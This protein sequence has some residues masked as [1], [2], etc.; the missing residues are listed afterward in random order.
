MQLPY[1]IILN[2]AILFQQVACETLEYLL[3]SKFALT[4]MEAIKLKVI[5]IASNIFEA[6]V[7][8]ECSAENLNQWDS[9]NH[10][11]F[12]FALE[13]EF[14]VRFNADELSTLTSIQVIVEKIKGAKNEA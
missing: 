9:L 5:S 12:L 3:A 13:E 1:L 4:S 11:Q 6:E 14:S 10:I 8:S 2:I 7:T